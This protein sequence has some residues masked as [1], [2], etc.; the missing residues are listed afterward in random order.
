MAVARRSGGPGNSLYGS[1]LTG[2]DGGMGG[3]P[4]RSNMCNNDENMLMSRSKRDGM[5]GPRGYGRSG[6]GKSFTGIKGFRDHTGKR[7]Y[8]GYDNKGI[9]AH[10]RSKKL[11]RG[12]RR[13]IDNGVFL[14]NSDAGNNNPRSKSSH[15][16][17]P[18]DAYAFKRTTTPQP[19]RAPN[20]AP[21]F[22]A[23]LGVPH[24]IKKFGLPRG[25][26]TMAMRLNP[27]KASKD[28]TEQTQEFN[29]TLEALN[30]DH[31]RL[32]HDAT[33]EWP[34]S[35]VKSVVEGSLEKYKEMKA[36]VDIRETK[37]KW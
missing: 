25:R 10:P 31:V 20:S 21:N 13:L 30:D 37:D 1:H 24:K 4:G 22:Y 26:K 27:N 35:D 12:S 8:R 6:P 17:R 15:N 36:R 14:H 5:Q 11:S 9:L 3:L 16:P 28:T 23:I 18:H 34:S 32:Y 7:P 29:Q 33:G 2:I 19:S